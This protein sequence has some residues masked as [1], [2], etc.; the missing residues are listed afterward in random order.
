MPKLKEKDAALALM[1]VPGIGS[2]LHNR[3]LEKF[4]SAREVWEQSE[5]A[6][7][8]VDFLPKKSIKRIIQG[9][10]INRLLDIKK[11]LKKIGAW[12]ICKG[13]Q[14]YPELLGAISQPPS[15]LFGLGKMEVLKKK[16]IAIVGSRRASTYGVKVAEMFAKGLSEMGIC[17][18]SGLAVGIDAAA[19]RGALN[20]TGGT[21]AVKGCGLDV[22][23]PWRN[24]RLFEKIREN[25][26]V[27]SEFL[28][29]TPPEAGNFPARN[30]I[31]SGLSQAVLVIEASLKSGSL[32]TAYLSLDE[33]RDVMSVPGSIFSFTS[34]GCH[35]LIQEG[36][37]LVTNVKDVVAEMGLD[38]IIEAWSRN[39]KDEGQN[40]FE[41]LADEKR[42]VDKLE[43][44][45]QHIDEIAARCGMSVAD[46]SRIL[47]ELELKGLAI[48]CGGGCYSINKDC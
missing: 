21:V 39:K 23:Y 8:T 22:P 19:H 36:A 37:K 42:V 7:A 17:V 35:R 28:P 34:Q 27:I 33:G 47:L 48:S 13:D 25:G 20:E 2:V 46:V 14:E 32:I 12:M 1:A 38:L 40:V 18:I 26:A 24:K 4:G 30:R 3:L 5:K 29:G 11:D 15:I 6:L 10:D 41:L 44:E 43:A 16:S 9:P 45:P 31:I